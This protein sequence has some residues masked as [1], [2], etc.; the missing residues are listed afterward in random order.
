MTGAWPLLALAVPKPG[1]STP[2]VTSVEVGSEGLREFRFEAVETTH[3]LRPGLRVPAW[4]FN[5]QVPGPEIRVR[6]GKRVRL[7]LFN[8]SPESHPMHLHGHYFQVVA[9]GA[10]RLAEPW[11]VKDVL[12]LD[13]MESYEVE[14][15]ADN[16]GVWMFHCHQ[17]HHADHDL[18]ILIR[19]L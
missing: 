14:F 7:R 16:P 9:V 8:M 2:A 3:A 10:Q 15:L 5:G 13:P 6:E 17:Q 4:G 18:I 19:Y 12:N 11:L 1:R